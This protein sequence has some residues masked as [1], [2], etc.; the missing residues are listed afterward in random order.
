MRNQLILAAVLV[1]VC[2]VLVLT[3][4]QRPAGPF[5]AA[6]AA[7]GQTAFQTNCAT[8]H[9]V[10][11]AG[12]ND[13]PALAGTQFIANWGGRSAGDLIGFMQAAMPPGNATLGEQNYI[14]IAA[15]I[16]QSNGASAG[17]AALAAA[18]TQN[19]RE[20]ATGQVA[21][22][23]QGKQGKQAKQA[24]Q[25]KQAPAAPRGLTVAGEAKN[26][27]PVTDGMLRNPDPGD[28]L[29]IRHD[30]HADNF[31][32]LREV[33][34]SNVQDLR[35]VWT[36]AM[37][38]GTN[39]SAPIVHNG[40]LF[41]NNPGNIV[42]ALDARTGDL[43]WENRIGE[44]DTGSSQR[45]LAMY[46]DKIYVTSGDAHIYAL[47]ARTGK[48]V[49]DTVIGDRSQTNYSTSSGPIIIK[50]KVVQ[51]LGGG[52]CSRYQ[53]EKCFISAYDAETGKLVWKFYTIAKN[54]DPGG[55]SWGGLADLFRAGGETWITGSYD[56][57][58]NMTYWGTAQSKPWMRVSRHSGNGATLYANSTVALDADTGKLKW[59]FSHAPGE[60]LD[61]DEVFE[62]VL[63]DDNGQKLVFSAGK[64]G[65]LWK[66]DRTNGKYL[67]HKETVFQNVYDS[68]DPQ[69]GEPHYRNDIVEQQIGQWVQSCPT[70]EG[71]HN[72]HAMTYN[73]PNNQV[74]IPVAQ[75]CQEMNAQAVELVEGGGN[76]GGA[77]RRFYESPGSNGNVGKLA[78]YDV[79]TLKENWKLEQH[80]P[81][82][83]AVLS[84][85]GGVAFVGDMNR[86]F[87]AVDAKTGKVLW[88][89]RLGTSVQGFPLS[90]AVNGKQYIA[91][92]AGLGGG[93]PRMVPSV[94]DPDVH[95]PN[96][97]A[98][99]YVFALPDKR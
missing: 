51:G 21:A 56:P 57:D 52:G 97:G 31:S 24:K 2:G 78:A 17:T 25:G 62:R 84:T 63:V 15:F 82:M 19:I 11:L 61:L 92:T 77:A 43:I 91:V 50:G 41:I 67:G 54:G 20:Y 4:Q 9:G 16:L 64:V 22:Q 53:N 39:Q 99:L 74:I 86:M 76:A 60:S 35:L 45:G 13:A 58:L 5:T 40:V 10:D 27:T 90:F 18:N 79:R 87:R 33:T 69:T 7:A 72:W 49:W 6:Q 68:F 83:T 28:W 66:L 46:D 93:S 32:S 26:F 80:S 23:V 34:A 42:Q 8:C 12:R 38:N 65:I 59:W 71:G 73:Q 75:S 29:M 37:N 14:N 70:S 47:N 81:F 98:Q 55:D 89:T 30:Y 94:L 3:G 96:Y 88:E 36:W 44:N 1:A 95:Y 85:A 48:N